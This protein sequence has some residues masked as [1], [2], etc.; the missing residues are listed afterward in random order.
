[1]KRSKHKKSIRIKKKISKGRIR[2]KRRRSALIKAKADNHRRKHRQKKTFKGFLAIVGS[3]IDKVLQIDQDF[4]GKSFAK[5]KNSKYTTASV[6]KSFVCLIIFGIKRVYHANVHQDEHVLA[7][8]IGLSKFPS[9]AT[10]YRFLKEFGT[11]T[12]CK[13]VQRVNRD[14]IAEQLKKEKEIVC[15]GD[16]ST[17]QTYGEQKD[18]SRKGFNKKRPGSF[19]LQ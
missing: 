14:Q 11:R 4:Q 8:L 1:M 16:T 15:D 2:R 9:A 10:L 18:G 5:K 17:I 3:Y 19:C 6:I 12:F 7:K 13:R